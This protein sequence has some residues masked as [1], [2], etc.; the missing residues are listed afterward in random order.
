[1]KMYGR[2]KRGVV[3]WCGVVVCV[4]VCDVRYG[5]DELSECEEK[6]ISNDPRQSAHTNHH[7]LKD[8]LVK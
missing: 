8:G 6:E 1:M 3:V 7:N 2:S 5:E 4:C